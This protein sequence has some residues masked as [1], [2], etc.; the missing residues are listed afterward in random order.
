MRSRALESSRTTLW[1][2]SRAEHFA[3]QRLAH[4]CL[5]YSAHVP[6]A[7]TPV[8]S[9]AGLTSTRPAPYSPIS[10]CG[11]VLLIRGTRIKLFFAA[12]IAFLIAGELREPCPWPKPT[13]PPSTQATLFLAQGLDLRGPGE[14]RS[15]VSRKVVQGTVRSFLCRSGAVV[16]DEGG[17]VGSARA[18]L[19]KFPLQSRKQS[20]QQKRA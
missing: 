4:H 1:R 9:E 5:H 8:P 2:V 7:I 14:S 3:A 6:P 10:S 16:G 19:A 12:S 13:C 18:R 20:K 17:H 15:I 11:R